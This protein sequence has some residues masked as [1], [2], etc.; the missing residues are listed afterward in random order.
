MM[1]TQKRTV[2][3][4]AIIAVG[5]SGAGDGNRGGGSAGG[6][7]AGGSGGVVGE[8]RGSKRGRNM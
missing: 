8:R 5:T 1:P 6:G 3:T 2:P 7:S 4:S